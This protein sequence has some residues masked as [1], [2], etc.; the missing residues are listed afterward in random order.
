VSLIDR[1]PVDSTADHELPRQPS[2]AGDDAGEEAH[3]GG[4][5]GSFVVRNGLAIACFSLF[6]V[7]WASQAL[8]GWHVY[9]EDALTHGESTVG[10]GAYLLSGHFVEATFENWESEFL[11]MFAFVL[12][13]AWLVQRGSAES[14]SEHEEREH[15]EAHRHDPD[16]PWPVRRGGLWLKLYENSLL[17]AFVVL[18]LLSIV[19]HAFGGVAEYNEELEAHGEQAES[20]LEF[21]T[22]SDFWFQSFQ[23][24]QSEFLAVGSIVVLTIFLRQKGSPESK[25]VHAANWRT[26]E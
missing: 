16:A 9:N 7:F 13:T 24:W 26:G 2:S 15:P 8:T 6:F 14:K 11:Q 21:V 18:F 22:S 17:L 4:H 10:L 3:P 5:E 23:N 25:P 1:S 19:G 12:L 20:T